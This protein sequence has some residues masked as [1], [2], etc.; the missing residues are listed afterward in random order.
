MHD[1]YGLGKA[2]HSFA[3]LDKE[4]VVLGKREGLVGVDDLLGVILMWM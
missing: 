1:L 4:V 3:D 2:V